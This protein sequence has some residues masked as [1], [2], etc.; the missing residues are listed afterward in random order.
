MIAERY[1]RDSGQVDLS[2]E[3]VE[4]ILSRSKWQEEE[5]KEDGTL[6]LSQVEG[7]KDLKQKRQRKKMIEGAQLPADEL[8]RSLALALGAE[9]LEYAF[10]YLLMHRMC[11]RFLRSLKEACDPILRQLHTPTY[12]E[13]ETELPFVVGYIFVAASNDEREGAML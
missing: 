6:V 8:I 2:P 9:T 3:H 12:V 1:L 10:P 7:S 13:N 11:W 5:S 4:E